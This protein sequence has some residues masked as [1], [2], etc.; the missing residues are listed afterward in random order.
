MS[1]YR[2]TIEIST[3]GNRDMTDISSYVEDIVSRSKMDVGICHIFNNGSTGVIG[4]IEFEGLESV[5]R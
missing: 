1:V 5:Q 2:E 4:T 3:S